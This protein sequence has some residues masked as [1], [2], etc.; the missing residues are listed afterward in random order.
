MVGLKPSLNTKFMKQFTH[1]LLSALL[2]A[3]AAGCSTAPSRF[4]TLNAEA[5]DTA[6]A[7]PPCSVIVGPVSVPSAVDRPQVAVTSGPNRVEYDEFNRWA[8]PLGESIA[9]V[10]SADLG[11]LLGTPRAA[12][13]PLPDLG[14]AYRVTIRVERFES[15]LGGSSANSEALVDALWTVRGPA[16]QSVDS[17]RTIARER[18]PGSSYEALAAAHSRALA[19]LSTDIAAAIRASAAQ[20]H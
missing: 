15:V 2:A 18:A 10:V 4:Y 6:P 5:H 20:N 7:A 12:S 9:R 14:P 17:G 1:L 16:G 8:A 13:A 3:V 19:K 11:Q